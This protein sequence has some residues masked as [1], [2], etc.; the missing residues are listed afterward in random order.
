MSLIKILKLLGGCVEYVGVCILGKVYII[1]GN[2]KKSAVTVLSFLLQ[3][4]AHTCFLL[5]LHHLSSVL[6]VIFITLHKIPS[7]WEHIQASLAVPKSMA[8]STTI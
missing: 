1:G 3:D 5:W 6:L 2:K 8:I 4:L 7:A